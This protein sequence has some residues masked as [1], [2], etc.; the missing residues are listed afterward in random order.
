MDETET[1]RPL[2]R[3]VFD[4][5]VYYGSEGEEIAIESLMCAD[6]LTEEEVRE[7]YTDEQIFEHAMEMRNLDYGEEM[8]ALAAYF[9]GEKSDMSS[10]VNPLGGNR[11]LARG[12]VQ[13]YFGTRTGITVYDD[14]AQA[15]DC[16][17][18]R[19]GADNVFAD[20]EIKRIW[21][22][23]GSL[24]V[25]G[26][27]H[28]GGVVVELR[29]LT[30]AGERLWGELDCGEYLPEEGLSAMGKTYR[31]GDEDRFV[32]DLWE[33]GDLCT[34]P[35]YLEQAFGCPS[36]EYERQEAF[37]VAQATPTARRPRP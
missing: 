23:N 6:D 8:A 29:Q 20:C 26:A 30:D 24:F 34:R 9:G 12:A 14:F 36:E 3:I 10:F 5:D 31:E 15:T 17:P 35:R 18:S 21:D 11:I 33:C 27:H 37:R 32:R 13:L 4:E 7:S 19:F 22:E 2:E 28:D 25:A 1:L 16:S